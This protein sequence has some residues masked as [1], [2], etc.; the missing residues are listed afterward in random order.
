MLLRTLIAAALL[1]AGPSAA[2]AHLDPGQHG[3]FAAGFTHPVFGLDHVL[4]MIA[5]GLWAA[6]LGG[7]A[8]WALP[9]TFVT[10]MVVGF[11]LSLGGLPIP[12]VE[13][14]ILASV[15][16]FGLVVA[17]AAPVPLWASIVLIAVFGICHGHAHGGEIGQ[18]GMFAFAAGFVLATIVLHAA[19]LV[20]GRGANIAARGKSK[21]ASRI[22]QALGALTAAGGLALA[23]GL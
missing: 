2:F 22:I 6:L 7:K 8:L 21:T 14:A 16:V 17:L 18:A 12:F 20:I 4:A 13:S 5:V 3:S 23:A 11:L 19:G 9:T 10:G 15:I 1:L